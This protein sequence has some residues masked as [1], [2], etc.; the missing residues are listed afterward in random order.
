MG[1][2]TQLSRS[3]TLGRHKPGRVLAAL[4]L[5][6]G[7]IGAACGGDDAKTDTTETAGA[8]TTVADTAAATTVP[9]PTTAAEEVPVP[10]GTMKFAV[11]NDTGNPWRPSEVIC[12]A[13][14]H[15]ILRNIFD[16][17]TLPNSD[18]SWSPYLAESL[19][20][21]DDFTEWRI[22]AREGVTFHD[23]TAFDGAA[24]VDNLTRAKT[25]LVWGFSLRAIEAIAVDPADPMVAVVTMN[26]PW[27]A[28]PAILTTQPGYIASP[29]WLTAS[30][31]D[32]T[33][34]SIPVGTGPFVYENYVAGEVFTMTRNDSYWNA[35]YPFLDAIEFSWIGDALSRRDALKSG[36]IDAMHTANGVTLSEF[37][38]STEFNLTEVTNQ[39]ETGYTLLHV[40]QEGSPLNDRRVR[41]ALAYATDTQSL[42]DVVGAGV[43]Q[44]ANGPFSPTQIGYLDDSGFP[45]AQDMAK[46][47]ELIAEY[48]AEFPGPITLAL[49]TTVDETNLTTAQFQQQWFVEAGID[50]VTIDQIDQAAYTITAALGNFQV[51]Q[52]RLHGGFELDQQY[53]FWHSE[54]A[55]DV[56]AV[57]LNFGRIKDATLDAL[58]DENRASNDPVRKKEIAEEV[59]RLFGTECYNIW[60][61][62]TTWGIAT[63][64][65]VHGPTGF[66]LPDGKTA[67]F[68]AGIA[69]VVYPMTFW[70]EQ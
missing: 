24:I 3:R 67:V 40:S 19:E 28:F 14:C 18:G 60:G 64:L 22:T 68:G 10:G 30:D 20:P 51:F 41:C 50:E 16:T 2:S 37:R 53:Q 39:G 26:T 34:K 48:K 31:T 21:N 23:G 7:L 42:I 55:A 54:N 69:G 27:A 44:L 46:A 49:A 33:L 5:S 59:N 38:E 43:N 8:D 36:T 47:Q 1:H 56:G 57:T 11:E 45:E 63:Q 52:W 12:A 17:L 4:V 61:S 65:A 9:P 13:S 32:E 6:A 29:T 66:E 15:Q 35:P 58:L 70:V 25:G 62:Y